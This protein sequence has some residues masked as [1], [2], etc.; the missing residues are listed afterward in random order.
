[1]N[2]G[3]GVGIGR[4]SKVRDATGLLEEDVVGVLPGKG[5]SRAKYEDCGAKMVGS[6]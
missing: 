3:R 2:K 6:G 5:T 4:E 1:M